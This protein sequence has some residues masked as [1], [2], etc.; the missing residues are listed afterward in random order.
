MCACIYIYRYRYIPAKKLMRESQEP[1][2]KQTV[3]IKFSLLFETVGGLIY[4]DTYIYI[5]VCTL[6]R[7]YTYI[8]VYIYGEKDRQRCYLPVLLARG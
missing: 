5:Y 2:K 1:T 7:V 8:Y 4:R 6:G 3:A